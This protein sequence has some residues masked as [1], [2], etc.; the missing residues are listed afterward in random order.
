M[1]ILKSEIEP[2]SAEGIQAMTGSLRGLSLTATPT[3]SSERS[4]K[5]VPSRY[6]CNCFSKRF[7][8]IYGFVDIHTPRMGYFVGIDIY[9][10]DDCVPAARS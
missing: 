5:I 2:F 7:E 6:V 4:R 3:V 10:C 8:S 9:G 1:K